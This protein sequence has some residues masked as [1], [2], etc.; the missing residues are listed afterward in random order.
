VSNQ[1]LPSFLL[2]ADA[3]SPRRLKNLARFMETLLKDGKAALPLRQF[4]EGRSTAYDKE[5][6]R[7]LLHHARTD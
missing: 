5:T 1:L 2:A 4:A 7:K 3:P 6:Q